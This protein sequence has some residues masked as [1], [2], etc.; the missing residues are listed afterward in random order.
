VTILA[1]GLGTLACAG[2][3]VLWWMLLYANPYGQ[4]G[5]TAGTYA[6]G[7]LMIV[8]AAVGGFASVKAQPYWMY[9]LFALSFLPVGLYLTGAPGLFRWIGVLDL[10]FLFA[11]VLLH[12][13]M[14]SSTPT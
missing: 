9:G 10:I 8:F 3:I 12:L 4:G 14:R 11:A 6:V 5:R 13:R 2:C 7:W 1:R